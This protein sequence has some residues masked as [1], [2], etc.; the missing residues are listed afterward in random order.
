V[1]AVEL[2]AEQLGITEEEVTR[3]AESGGIAFD[4]LN[5][6]FA[7]ASQEG[8]QFAG[9]IDEQI[10]T[11]EGL[12]QVVRG[13]IT[14][15]LRD[16]GG[17]LLPTIGNI[18][19]G[20]V[21]PAFTALTQ[22][23]RDNADAWTF[24]VT[25]SLNFFVE[26]VTR[27]VRLLVNFVG[28]IA[29]IPQF[30]SDNRRAFQ[31][32]AIGILT[33]NAALI[34]ANFNLIR[35]NVLSLIAQQRAI[36]LAAAQRVAAV[37][38]NVFSRAQALL[39]IVL[40]ANPIGLVVVAVAA[41]VA[42]FILLIDQ[43]NSVRK[44]VADFSGTV[45]DLNDRLG[46]WFDEIGFVGDALRVLLTPIRS[47]INLIGGFFNSLSEGFGILQS[48]RIGLAELRDGFNEFLGDETT[49]AADVRLRFREENLEELRAEISD[50]LLGVDLD[51]SDV[52]ESIQ[53]IGTQQEQLDTAV[54][55]ELRDG[56][57]TLRAV[58]EETGESLENVIFGALANAQTEEIPLSQAIEEIGDRVGV[59]ADKTD[60]LTTSFSGLEDEAE[61]AKSAIDLLREA[62]R[63]LERQVELAFNIDRP[64]DN[65][66]EKLEELDKAVI[67]LR[68][69]L[70]ALNATRAVFDIEGLTNEQVE[71]F[72]R[73]VSSAEFDLDTSLFEDLTSAQVQVLTEIFNTPDFELVDEE[74]LLSIIER[75]RRRAAVSLPFQVD[76]E[77]I[78]TDILQSNLDR[79][80]ITLSDLEL[81]QSAE[82]LRIQ[83]ALANQVITEEEAKERIRQLNK[84]LIEQ[85]IRLSKAKESQLLRELSE[86]KE[87]DKKLDLQGKISDERE[88]QLKLTAD[89][90]DLTNL[91]NEEQKIEEIFAR[92]R[93]NLDSTAIAAA[94]LFSDITANQIDALDG[95]IERQ[96][97]RVQDALNIAEEG[98]AELVQLEE[99]RLER[100]IIARE[101]A[102]RRQEQIDAAIIASTQAVAVAEA[103]TLAISAF[104]DGNPIAG[105]AQIVAAT[106]AIAAIVQAVQS[107]QGNIP[108]FYKGTED[109]GAGGEVDSKGGFVSILH[110]RERVVPADINKELA[111]IPNS[112]L[113]Q[114]VQMAKMNMANT[115]KPDGVKIDE[116]VESPAMKRFLQQSTMTR[117][118]VQKFI[119]DQINAITVD[120]MPSSVAI[121]EM[122]GKLM[123]AYEN[124]GSHVDV[125]GLQDE[126]ASIKR[127][128]MNQNLSS[129]VSMDDIETVLN[130]REHRRS[131]RN[132]IFKI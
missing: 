40:S 4:E 74:Q 45:L 130:T 84:E 10:K 37:A 67:E 34:A 69:S 90:D 126:L 117:D 26:G 24:F 121:P 44:F 114:L 30:I 49:F 102:Q 20:T 106:A 60:R 73:A 88:K 118:E 22:F 16:L 50:L 3:L 94:Q 77:P 36:G 65:T 59:A 127:L 75:V 63:K 99:E 6:A 17:V 76:V 109:T 82:R 8:G 68:E 123:A 13:Q 28:L 29:S 86:T 38:T 132:K 81:S 131:K 18:L 105:V 43:V 56:L 27:A 129:N 23:I 95:Q 96:R 98:N 72:A 113:P 89:L 15:V 66:I 78:V 111:G 58:A 71:A 124:S 108:T 79:E 32:L 85:Q 11:F 39:N 7:K 47:A 80:T 122:S 55:K 52:L 54:F 21:L 115:E 64:F 87:V 101:R 119:S 83:E 92:I 14:T 9:S 103:I 110:P 91:E 41:L 48:V 25:T 51:T 46:D 61:K 120:F 93:Q 5:Q 33:F 112:A 19:R 42:G 1:P 57:D 35:S 104:K 107:A 62:V 31:L 70:N 12:R 53:A 97:Q 128:L 125:S 2:L 116:I 100:L